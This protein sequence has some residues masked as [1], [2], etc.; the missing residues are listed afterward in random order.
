MKYVSIA[1][2]PGACGNFFSRCLN[3]L[4]NA[5]CYSM[6]DD[7]ELTASNKL[8]ILDYTSVINK[9]FNTRN[10][11]DFEFSVD[12]VVHDP[13]LL[14]DAVHIVFGHPVTNS[15]SHTNLYDLAGKDDE[16]YNFYIDT[17]DHFE[18]AYMNALY[19]DSSLQ[20]N[21][22][23]NGQEML[24][25]TDVH[26]IQLKNFLGDW[27]DFKVEFIKTCTIIGRTPS[28]DELNAIKTLYGQWKQTTLE[29]KDLDSFKKLLGFIR[30][31]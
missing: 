10:W 24:R 4:D 14:S 18:W 19:K 6:P 13:T 21:W 30:D 11:C 26:K 23:Q 15:H 25:N 22:F 28:I 5:H 29:Y 12:R 16:V 7:I 27:K 17:G 8:K 9:S 2:L 3:L 31:D 1:F 20:A